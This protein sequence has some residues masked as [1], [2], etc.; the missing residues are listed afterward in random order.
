MGGK[1]GALFVTK[2]LVRKPKLIFCLETSKHYFKKKD[3]SIPKEGPMRPS[4]SRDIYRLV[5]FGISP[6]LHLSF[7]KKKK[8]P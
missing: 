8:N 3:L 7:V 1:Y 4:S 5:F 6:F 2:I